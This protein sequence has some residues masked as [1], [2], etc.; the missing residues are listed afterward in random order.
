MESKQQQLRN[1]ITEQVAQI[2]EK[3]KRIAGREICS[4]PFLFWEICCTSDAGHLGNHEF[5]G[6]R[7]G[8]RIHVRWMSEAN[9]KSQALIAF[10]GER[11]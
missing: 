9:R 7:N 2:S 11:I 1:K 8:A 3:A 6:V 4:E 10:P 5:T